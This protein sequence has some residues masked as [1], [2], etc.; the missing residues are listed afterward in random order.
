[1]KV[2]KRIATLLL[3]AFLVAGVFAPVQTEAASLSVAGIKFYEWTGAGQCRMVT[4]AQNIY[5][6]Q[7]QIFNNAGKLVKTQ[8]SSCYYL[9]SNPD[10]YNICVVENLPKLSCAFVRVRARRTTGSWCAW[11]PKVLIV[12]L[13]GV[14]GSMKHS[15]A[16]DM[17]VKLSWSK[18]TGATDYLV[19]LSTSG[20]GGWKK[21]ATVKGTAKSRSVVLSSFNG[22]KF[23][24]YQNYYYKVIA[25]RKMNGKYYSSN[26]NAADFFVNG[27]YF[28]TVFK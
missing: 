28:K 17:K 20:K 18:V 27:F 3:A 7:Y 2:M 4:K 22:K 1:M 13:I 19:Y 16:G 24:K 12:P 14:A 26:G 9:V 11:S 25:R 15:Q 10:K 21:V 23:V 6:F 8:K 5:E